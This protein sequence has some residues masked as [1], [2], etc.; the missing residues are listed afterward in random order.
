MMN[1]AYVTGA[2]IGVVTAVLA[3]AGGYYARAATG[4]V[5][6]EILAPAGAPPQSFADIVQRVAPAVVSIETVGKVSPSAV[7]LGQDQPFAFRFGPPGPNGFDFQFGP[8]PQSLVPL[9]SAGS[10]FFISPDGYVLT[11]NHVVQGADKITVVSKDGDRLEAHLVGA[12]AATDLAVLKV[13][14]DR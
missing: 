14:G 7:G 13:A 3:A 10:G 2:S 4:P 9:R 8:S 1:K 11:N 5:N 12:D 6:P